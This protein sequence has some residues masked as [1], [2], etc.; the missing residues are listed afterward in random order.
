MATTESVQKPRYAR[1]ICRCSS[2]SFL[3]CGRL[4]RTTAKTRHTWNFSHLARLGLQGMVTG[5]RLS[6]IP[7]SHRMS[8]LELKRF[9]VLQSCIVGTCNLAKNRFSLR[10]RLC[11]DPSSRMR[12]SR[13][14]TSTDLPPVRLPAITPMSTSAL[15]P[16]IPILFEAVTT[17]SSCVRHG[18]RTEAPT[19][20]TIV[21]RRRD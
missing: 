8:C 6:C 3:R 5:Q 4:L 16:F 18:I 11:R 7:K 10:R 9:V 17:S 21:T 1:S 12:S 14:G 20:S 2:T 19:N 15:S 13:N